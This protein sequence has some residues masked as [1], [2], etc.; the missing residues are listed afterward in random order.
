MA[1][2]GPSPELDEHLLECPICLERLRQPKS[3][4]CLH[5]FCQECLGIYITNASTTAFPWPVCRRMTQPPANQTEAK[6]KWAEQ[7][8]TNAE[9]QKLIPL[10]ERSSE[11][12]YCKPCQTRGDLTNP[13]KFWCKLM[14]L[15]LC[16]T[17]K[18][19]HHDVLHNECDILDITRYDSRKTKQE[20]SVPKCD[21]HDETLIWYCEDHKRLGCHICRNKDH[22]RR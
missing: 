5:C 2:G 19:Q 3:L 4:P 10:R 7:F 17:C 21:Q 11:P 15:N 22:V 12:L 9:I 6:D 16:E 18:V 8:P 1:E 13:A 20:Q 14:N